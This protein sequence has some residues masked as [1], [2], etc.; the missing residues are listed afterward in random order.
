MATTLR[1]IFVCSGNICRSPMAEGL[2]RHSLQEASIPAQVISMGTLGIFGRP[3]SAHAVRVCQ[4]AGLDLSKHSSQGISLGLLDQAN[5]V[6]VMEQAH[7][8][9]LRGMNAGLH[10]VALFSRFDP[11]GPTDVADPIGQTLEVYEACFARLERGMKRLVSRA[12]TGLLQAGL[13]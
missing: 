1:L 13:I 7:I 2:A 5:L 3:A 12:Q 8:D 9:T 6:L 11:E 4:T 10:N